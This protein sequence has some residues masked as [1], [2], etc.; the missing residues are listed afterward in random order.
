MKN[1]TGLLQRLIAD[2]QQHARF[3]NSLSYL[4]YRG[5]RKI[6]RALS[7]RDVDD[8]VLSHAMEESRHALYFKKLAI[9]T[10]GPAFKT[11]AAENM[12][13]PQAVKRYFFEL[14]AG[15]KSVLGSA[16]KLAYLFVTWLIEERAMHVY[17]EYERLLRLAGHTVTLK[18]VLADEAQHLHD[19]KAILQTSGM[20]KPAAQLFALEERLF[21][22][23][24]SAMQDEAVLAHP[25]HA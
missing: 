10:G 9:K 20:E 16:P 11:F 12:L 22:E 2:D 8:E 4:E 1:V 25:V 5:A 21:E 24:W 13:A 17:R 14:D 23:T 15:A 6:M 7:T 3:L 19:V 18:P